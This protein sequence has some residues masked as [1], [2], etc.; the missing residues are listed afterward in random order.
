MINQDTDKIN[1]LNMYV[2]YMYIST[3]D[4]GVIIL[5]YDVNLNY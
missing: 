1:P 4:Q 3:A 2:F 5:N